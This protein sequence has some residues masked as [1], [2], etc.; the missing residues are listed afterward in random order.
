MLVRHRPR[1]HTASMTPGSRRDYNAPMNTL[2]I[3]NDER[4]KQHG[5]R[6]PDIRSALSGWTR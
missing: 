3:V 5:N 2:G 4:F 1:P 6:P